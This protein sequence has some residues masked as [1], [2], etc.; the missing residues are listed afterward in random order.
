MSY[1][2]TQRIPSTNPV[3][4]PSTVLFQEDKRFCTIPPWVMSINTH[5]EDQDAADRLIDRLDGMERRLIKRIELLEERLGQQI[6]DLRNDLY[7]VIF[8][9][10]GMLAVVI[11]LSHVAGG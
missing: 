6:S 2:G 1:S 4:L 5:Q 3:K 11:V 9:G 8:L 10:F 7:R